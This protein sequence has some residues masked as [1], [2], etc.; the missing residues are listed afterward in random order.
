MIRLNKNPNIKI[1]SQINYYFNPDFVYIPINSQ[2]LVKQN[3]SITKGQFVTSNL[4]SPISG[5]AMGIKNMQ[6]EKNMQKCLVIANDYKEISKNKKIKMRQITI[7]KII[8]ILTENHEEK[9]LKKFKNQNRFDRIII[10]AINDEPYVYNNIFILKENISDLLMIIDHLSL[11]YKSDNNYLIIKNNEANIIN[12]CLNVIGTYPNIK[13]T[14][15]NDEYLLGKEEFIVK[16]LKVENSK[17]LYLEVEDLNIL[18][19]Y[20]LGKDN[21]TKLI[22][23][24]GDAILENKTILTKKNVML[25]DIIKKYIKIIEKQYIVIIN[26]LMCGYEIVTMDKFIITNNINSIN[27]IKPPIYKTTECINCG[28]CIEICPKKVNPINLQNIKNCINCGLCSYICPCFINLKK[29]LE[30]G[31]NYE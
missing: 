8:K 25:L 29:R 27:I 23:I 13:L 3:E 4:E 30:K 11:I 10:S 24:S 21:S 28:K 31:K 5:V 16:K 22:T 18:A 26:G 9:L 19:N 7:D 6:I 12:E 17:N 20:L 15:V 1:N 14:L 2:I